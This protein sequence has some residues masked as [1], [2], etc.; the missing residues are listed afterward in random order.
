[1]EDTILGVGSRVKHPAYED[2]VIIRIHKAVYDVIFIK[3]GLKQVGK[4]YDKWEIIE[5]MEA[6]EEVTFTEAEKSLLKILKA[7]NLIREDVSIADKFLNGTIIFK[8]QDETY[9]SKEMPIE[10][11]FHKLVMVRDRLRVIEQKI[12][13]N[14]ELSEAEKVNLQQYITR[15]YGSL[16]SFNILFKKNEDNF[17][18]QRGG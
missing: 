10:T 16:T 1:M 4:H 18:G 3:Y 12:N 8:P 17:V 6:S 7:Y 2:G 15:I 11:F 13:S 9:S 5:Y 14:K